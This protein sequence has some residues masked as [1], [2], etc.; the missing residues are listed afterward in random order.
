MNVTLVDV[1]SG[2]AASRFVLTSAEWDDLDELARIQLLAVA[3]RRDEPR[4]SRR[5]PDPYEDY[6]LLYA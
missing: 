4:P 6:Q 5:E 3:S 1:A 2:V